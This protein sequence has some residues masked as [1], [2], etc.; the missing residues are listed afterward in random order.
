MWPIVNVT[1][2]GKEAGLKWQSSM[3]QHTAIR[4]YQSNIKCQTTIKAIKSWHQIKQVE[5]II[6]T[7]A[8]VQRTVQFILEVLCS[9]HER[10]LTQST[11]STQCHSQRALDED[12][13][14]L[15]CSRQ[16]S[17]PFKLVSYGRTKKKKVEHRQKKKLQKRKIKRQQSM[18]RFKKIEL[19]I[20]YYYLLR[21][22]T[23]SSH[24]SNKLS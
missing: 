7:Q 9:T 23:T 1:L 14:G 4:F 3:Q 8:N 17:C 2:I 21:K 24:S 12:L 15:P 18:H 13:G 19:C 22:Q 5:R 16:Y 10:W 20:I 6:K 11:L